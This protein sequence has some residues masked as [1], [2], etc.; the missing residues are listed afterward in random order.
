MSEASKLRPIK[1]QVIKDIIPADIGKKEDEPEFRMVKPT[2]LAVEEKYQRNLSEKSMAL[3]RKIFKDFQ[4][5]R[6]KPPVVAEC[7][8]GQLMV[9]DGQH[10]A[11]AC[12]SL[13]DLPNAKLKKIPVMIVSAVT[14]KER[15]AA[16]MGHNRDRVAITSP[17][18]YYSAVAA[19]EETA[20]VVEKAL[21][22]TGAV[23]VRSNPPKYVEG[24]T[25][26]AGALL[27]LAGSRGYTGVKRI[28]DIMMD[29]K[30]APIIALELGA[31]ADLLYGKDWK[32]KFTDKDLATVIRSKSTSAWYAHAEATVRKGMPMQMKRA[33][34][35]AWF[36]AVPKKKSGANGNEIKK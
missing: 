18:L 27:R 24:Q 23:I 28:L 30:R 32:G 35:I 25:M 1:A 8:G 10:T 14:I 26:A 31:C 9:I 36:R 22:E 21:K 4:W 17:Q 16:F 5:S 2:D 29:A 13:A 6:Y 3:I 34:A 33:I 19:G 12:A 20:L 15:A 7:E 11:I